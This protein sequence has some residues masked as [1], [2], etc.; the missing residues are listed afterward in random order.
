M[1][2]ILR[3]ALLALLVAVLSAGRMQSEYEVKA[4]YVYRFTQFVEYPAREGKPF[5][6]G[7]L[8]RD[9]FGQSIDQA[10]KD[11][12]IYGRN[13][14]VRRISSVAEAKECDLVFIGASAA[15]KLPELLGEIRALPILTVADSP[16]L[17]AKGV[18]I[19]LFMED[20]KVRFEVNTISAKA[21][22]LTISSRLL[23]LAKTV[24]T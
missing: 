24:R 3:I 23:A 1:R 17:M 20:N 15:G 12:K 11:K 6:V 9:P 19:N 14:V 18:M 8:G 10:F 2:N 22:G 16:G 5:V 7:I 13:P 21:A 4:A